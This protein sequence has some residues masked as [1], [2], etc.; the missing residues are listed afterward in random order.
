MEAR[1]VGTS[2]RSRKK[3]VNVSINA[4][5]AA[6]AKAAGLNVSGVL[7][8]ALQAELQSLREKRWREDNLAAI[9]ASNAEL[10][11]DG[12]WCDASRVW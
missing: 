11:R 2:E 9:E 8:K 7:E 5:L 10:E 1:M 12:L 6:E 3:A 4:A